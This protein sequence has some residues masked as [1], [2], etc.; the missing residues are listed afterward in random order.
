ME[1]LNKLFKKEP[2]IKKLDNEFKQRIFE[3]FKQ[4]EH[5]EGIQ[6]IIHD[7]INKYDNYKDLETYLYY[8]L[9]ELYLYDIPN[10]ICY[11]IGCDDHIKSIDYNELWNGANRI[12]Y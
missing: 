5:E 2:T 11:L 12:E 6:L 4:F 7:N 3:A 8:T 10:P 9:R 1:L